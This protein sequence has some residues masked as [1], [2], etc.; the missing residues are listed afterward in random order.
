MRYLAALVVTIVLAC[1]STA[2][3]TRSASGAAS[4]ARV[5]APES[6]NASLDSVIQ[7]LLTS[8]AAD[9]HAHRPPEPVGFRDVRIGHIMTDS[10]ERQYVLCG[11]FLPRQEGGKA[12]WTSFVT[13]KTSVYEQ[14]LGAQ[15]KAFLQTTSVEWDRVNDLSSA[16]LSRLDSLR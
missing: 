15:A 2:P 3:V 4:P 14:W 9:F 1:C 13:T 8:A 10:G 11:E 5:L 6:Q 16:L 7:Y 12:Q